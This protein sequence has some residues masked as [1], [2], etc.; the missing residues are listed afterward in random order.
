MQENAITKEKFIKYIH[1]KVI[2]QISEEDKPS[3]SYD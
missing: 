3:P 2:K 1:C